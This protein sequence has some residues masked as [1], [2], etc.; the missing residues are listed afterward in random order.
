MA[1]NTKVTV[2]LFSSRKL[3]D[4]EGRIG[5]TVSRR[6]DSKLYE[7]SSTRNDELFLTLAS[8]STIS[9]AYKFNQAF[10]VT[11]SS[12]SGMK[13]LALLIC[14]LCMLLKASCGYD[15]TDLKHQRDL[16]FDAITKANRRQS[17]PGKD[18]FKNL[19]EALSSIKRSGDQSSLFRDMKAVLLR[20]SYKKTFGFNKIGVF[21][22]YCGPGNV[23]GPKN[24]T[25]E[26]AFHDVDECCKAHDYCE[27][28][29]SSRADYDAYPDLPRKPFRFSSLSCEC[30]V[31]F[32][33]CVSRTNSAFGDLI[34]G[35][36]SVA[37][38]GC[39]QFE[40]K[41]EKCVKYDE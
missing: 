40:Y 33:N 11:F 3:V 19:I 31:A 28:C 18:D 22:N 20:N 7:Y 14:V 8:L 16:W 23:A 27:Q 24:E 13:P 12:F 5:K 15:E 34:L 4:S 2:A 10:L 35:I 30:D 6:L 38:I 36:Y 25:V 17:L 41:I 37:Q 29:I 39:F 26:G 1:L 21:T 32:Y 9:R